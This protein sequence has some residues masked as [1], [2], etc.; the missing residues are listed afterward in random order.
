LEK[1]AEE[2]I[3]LVIKNQQQS[4][5]FRKSH[6]TSGGPSV[7][8]PTSSGPDKNQKRGAKEKITLVMKNKCHIPL[9]SSKIPEKSHL[10]S[11]GPLVF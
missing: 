4:L 3:A 2:I 9:L 7:L 8:H 10:A 5:G 6:W 1:S 11:R